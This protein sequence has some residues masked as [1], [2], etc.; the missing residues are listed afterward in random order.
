MN[1]HYTK[2]SAAAGANHL[3]IIDDQDEFCEVNIEDEDGYD[4]AAVS[5]N[6]EDDNN[7]NDMRR[8]IQG[9]ERGKNRTNMGGDY[10]SKKRKGGLA[11]Y[12]QSA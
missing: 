5:D 12:N 11:Q 7:R 4:E 10:S 3:Q 2:Q 8:H 9:Q 1:N 6:D